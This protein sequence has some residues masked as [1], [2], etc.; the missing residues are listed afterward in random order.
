MILI[1]EFMDDPAVDQ[2]RATHDVTYDPSLADR[3]D[4][5]PSMMG[6]VT[7]L[8]V[9]NR[10]QVTPALLDAAPQLKC[11]GRLGVGLDNIDMDACAARSVTVYP[12]TGANNLCVAEYV[13]STSLQLLRSAFDA[14]AAMLAGDWPRQASAG[15]ELAGKT[16]GLVGFGA[17][18]QDTAQLARGMG[19]K[20]AAYDPY[21]PPNHKAWTGVQRCDLPDLLPISD[22][23]SLHVPLTGETRHL[24]NATALGLMKPDAI[25]INAARGGTLD[26]TALTAALSANRLGGAALDVFE[27]EPMTAQS[28]AKFQGIANL[29]LTPH[30][31]GVTVESNERVSSLIAEKIQTHLQG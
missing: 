24:I 8:I 23:L 6:D 28:G 3:Q 4:D 27:I 18:A 14:R 5:I 29:I 15:R 19:M 2:L 11:V 7:A 30:I 10:T 31:A 17:I 25:V 1:T 20:I 9:R 12:A 21:L 16:L 26:E 22:V 13:I